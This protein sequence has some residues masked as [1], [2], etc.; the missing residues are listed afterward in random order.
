M[1]TN[2]PLVLALCCVLLAGSATA[3]EIQRVLVLYSNDRLLPANL[4]ADR[5]LRETIS[6]S[7]ELSAEFLGYPRFAGKAYARTIS[8]E[9]KI[10]APSKIAVDPGNVRAFGRLGRRAGFARLTM[11]TCAMCNNGARR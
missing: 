7:V 1:L 8:N 10:C 6:N 5:G 2:L 9:S 3:S 4:D 11:M